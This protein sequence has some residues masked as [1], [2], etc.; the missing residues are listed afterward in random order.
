VRL[1]QSRNAIET[2]MTDRLTRA[3]DAIGA[4]FLANEVTTPPTRAAYT[5]LNI[6]AYPIMK[7]RRIFGSWDR[8]MKLIIK[9]TKERLNARPTVA[10][11]L[12]NQTLNEGAALNYQF[13]S[14]TFAESNA[15]Q[16]L[17]YSIVTKPAWVTFTAGTRTFTGTAPAVTAQTVD[18]VTVRAMDEYGVYVDASFTITVN[19]V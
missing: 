12:V 13:A 4:V 17:T 5:A 19:N 16:S 8:A 14:N 9:H 2:K 15:G 10:N 1:A 7:V 6:A 18:T 3:R 11:A